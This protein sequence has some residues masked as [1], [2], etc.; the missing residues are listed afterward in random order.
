MCCVA[1]F[2]LSEGD[3]VSSNRKPL[4]TNVHSRQSQRG[5]MGGLAKAAKYDT[6]EATAAARAAFLRTFEDAADP[7]GQLESA[8]RERRAISLRKL[9]FARLSYASALK[10][11]RQASQRVK[12]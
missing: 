6:R 9:H 1:R 11:G 5:R 8:E 7:E 3:D 10:R 2:C 12:P 4:M